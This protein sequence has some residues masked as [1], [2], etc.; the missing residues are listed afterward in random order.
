MQLARKDMFRILSRLAIRDFIIRRRP[1]ALTWIT[2]SRW[3]RSVG[4]AA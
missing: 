1:G 4:G 3:A 2:R